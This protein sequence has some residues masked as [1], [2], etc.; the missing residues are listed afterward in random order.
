M[1]WVPFPGTGNA[2]FRGM[3][4]AMNM[5]VRKRELLQT[6]ARRHVRRLNGVLRRR[7]GLAAL[8]P[9][10]LDRGEAAEP[11]KSGG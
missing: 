1:D 2:P 4:T 3:K 11:A 6:M 9:S 5:A 8:S 10:L 7:P